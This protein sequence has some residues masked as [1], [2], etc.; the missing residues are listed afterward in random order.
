MPESLK[1]KTIKGLTWNAVNNFI[2]RGISFLL[3]ILLAR[4]LSPGDYGLIAMISV[5]IAI[6][7]VFIDSGMTNALIRKQDRS[8]ADLATVFYF[9][10]AVSC[11][12]YVVMFVSAPFIADF[13]RM[14]QLVSI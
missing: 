3:G 7:S 6:L 5:F 9:N 12:I 4:L 2:T 13:Y 11:L 10:L 14:P 8:E 1:Q